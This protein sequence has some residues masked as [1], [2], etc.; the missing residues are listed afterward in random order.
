MSHPLALYHA[1]RYPFLWCQTTEEERI[2]RDNRR[3]IGNSSS[4]YSWDIVA[5][6]RQ[7]QEVDVEP[8][9]WVWS[10]MEKKLPPLKAL[11][12]IPGL[13]EKESIIFMK[14]FHRYF[15]DIQV[16]R[17][18]LN[19]KE[20]LKSQGKTI[21]FLSAVN[22]IPVELQNDINMIDF[23]YPDREE[24]ARVLQLVCEDNDMDLP[25]NSERVVDAMMG[26][27]WESAES[28][29]CLSLSKLGQFDVRTILD[30]KAAQLQS[31][32]VL[33][34][35][36]YT[37][38]FDDVY[39]LEYMKQFVLDTI[40]HPEAR[41]ILIYGVPGTGKSL[42]AKA[43]G[44]ALERAI[45]VANF[46]AL[47]DKYQGQAEAKTAEMFKTIEAFGRPVIFADE[48]EKSFSGAEASRTDGGVG[49]RILGEFLKYQQDR[50]QNGSYWI[51]TCNSLD[52]I[53]TLSGGALVR[54]FDAIFFVDM[55][56]PSECRG[57]AKVW[58]RIK[59][60]S[61]PGDYDFTHYN[62]DNIAKLA[63]NLKMFNGDMEKAKRFVIPYGQAN[64]S[65]IEI[66]RDKAKNVC[67]PASE[68]ELAV[69][70]V[71]KRKVQAAMKGGLH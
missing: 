63:T 2:I 62:G 69:R 34:Y 35:G 11:E 66:I 56:T 42:F 5:G 13:M 28:A 44:N 59:G 15:V 60:V 52:D 65:Q 20:H 8:G 36:R 26:L 3:K 19:L 61:I 47:R 17:Q 33:Q 67:I 12:A 14:D 57:I 68:K 6:F 39:G 40:D 41:G 70:P 23:P 25:E 24:L 37:E 31:S 64:A 49:N 30:A 4:F 51:C 21:V 45:L 38:T 58:N 9:T 22:G 55:P 46:S 53:L 16:I 43:L 10:D 32:G 54:R 48:L 71:A 27:T 7:M 18:A 29:L 50:K 1:A